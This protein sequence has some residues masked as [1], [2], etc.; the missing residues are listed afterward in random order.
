MN[1]L[2]P[3]TLAR[4]EALYQRRLS[5][6]RFDRTANRVVAVIVG[7]GFAVAG[8]CY[9]KAASAETMPGIVPRKPATVITYKPSKRE[10]AAMVAALNSYRYGK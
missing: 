8:F 1:M 10:A 9:V 5:D 3:E 4:R 7:I 6:E 2:S